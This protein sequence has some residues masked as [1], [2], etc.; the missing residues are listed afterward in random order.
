MRWRRRWPRVCLTA[1][2]SGGR[3]RRGWWTR[4]SYYAAPPSNQTDQIS[5]AAFCASLVETLIYRH[6]AIHRGYAKWMSSG[7]GACYD[8]PHSTQRVFQ[9]FV[10][11]LAT[12]SVI[13]SSPRSMS[14][15]IFPMAIVLPG[16]PSGLVFFGRSRDV[17][18]SRRVNLPS[19][20]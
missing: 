11:R 5:N 12:P 13:S 4:S 15:V 8:A 14:F 16:H 19:W 6:N 1:E 2:G 20:G 9:A 17:P 7:L 18:S 3:K 10:L